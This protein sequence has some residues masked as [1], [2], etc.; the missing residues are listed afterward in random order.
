M[1]KIEE[2]KNKGLDIEW[3]MTIPASKINVILDKKYKELSQSIKIPGFRPGKVPITIIKKRYS[4]SIMTEIL[5]NLINDNLREVLLEKKIRPS[6][7][8]T[9]NVKSYE[10]GKDLSLNVVIQK[11][12]DIKQID[13]SEIKVE[14]SSLEVSD[15][16]IKNTLDDIAKKHERFLPLKKKRAAENGDL[17]LF[18]YEGMID[19]K[20]FDKSK[21]KDETVVLGS[22]KYIP[23]YEEQMVGLRINEDKNISVTFP[24]DYRETKIAGKKANFH[25]KIKDIQERVKKVP[26]DDQLAKELGEKNLDVL[27]EK[28]KEKI[29]TDFK[30]LSNLK[31]R[32]EATEILLK[33]NKFEIPSKMLEQEVNFLKSQSQDKKNEKEVSDI[34]KRR[35]KLGI[36][37]SSISDNNKINVEDSDLT[38]AVVEEAQKYPGKEKEVVEFYKNNPQMMNNLRGIA[39]EEKVMSFIVNSCK[40]IEKKCTMDQLFDSEFL[41][42]EKSMIKK[43]E[44]DK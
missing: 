16:D 26:I 22:N 41:K 8:P 24:S 31:M 7:Q 3:N 27:K 43:K 9:V 13:L 6:V 38:K 33:K 29:Q 42:T 28:V 1:T 44:K 2:I 19:G 5:D 17:V 25:L 34:A 36:I 32:R 14:K 40:K 20:A 4:K 35:V 21:G 12:P 15:S 37:I 10:E 23:G 39:L 11:M 18:D 30:T